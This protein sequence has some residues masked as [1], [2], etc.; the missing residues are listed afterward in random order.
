VTSA[1]AF[2]DDLMRIL[3]AA[4]WACLVLCGPLLVAFVTSRRPAVRRTL[5]NLLLTA[6]VGIVGYV[7]VVVAASQGYLRQL[8]D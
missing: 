4:F 3:T 2:P 5:R 8:P 1:V 6:C 7:A